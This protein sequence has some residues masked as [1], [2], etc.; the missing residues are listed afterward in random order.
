MNISIFIAAIAM[1]ESGNNP[2]AVGKAGE[3]SEYQI[4]RQVWK[5][6][7]PA[8]PFTRENA[9][10]RKVSRYVAFNHASE[11]E[12]SVPL[13]I[14]F[15]LVILS[16]NERDTVLLCAAGWHRGEAYMKRSWF[17]WSAETKDYADRVWNVYQDLKRKEGK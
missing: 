13:V 17:Q 9:K 2:A 15:P 12:K 16:K 11:L 6:Y 3:L 8:E 1:V 14:L 4:T 10:R 7:A 5:R